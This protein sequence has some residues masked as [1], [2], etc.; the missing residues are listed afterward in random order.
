LFPGFGAEMPDPPARGIDGTRPGHQTVGGGAILEPHL[1]A[2]TL[3]SFALQHSDAWVKDLEESLRESAL[4]A[5]LAEIDPKC[6]EISDVSGILLQP[7]TADPMT[8]DFPLLV[9]YRLP[10]KAKRRT[11]PYE[12]KTTE[13]RAPLERPLWDEVDSTSGDALSQLALLVDL[14]QGDR[15]HLAIDDLRGTWLV[16]DEDRP[17]DP[18]APEGALSRG[19]W[20]VETRKVIDV[21]ARRGSRAL[22]GALPRGRGRLVDVDVLAVA[23]IANSL[24]PS[25]GG[26]PTDLEEIKTLQQEVRLS[27]D[28]EEK[29]TWQLISLRTNLCTLLASNK[30]LGHYIAQHSTGEQKMDKALREKAEIWGKKLSQPVAPVELKLPDALR[31]EEEVGIL[32]VNLEDSRARVKALAEHSRELNCVLHMYLAKSLD[33]AQV[34]ASSVRETQRVMREQR[35][36]SPVKKK[37]SMQELAAAARQPSCRDS[38]ADIVDREPLSSKAIV[39]L[40]PKAQTYYYL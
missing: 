8:E 9:S 39:D 20:L 17:Y 37:T 38:R 21:D 5:A 33:T 40:C 13:G 10:T 29:L 22:E 4:K 3:F 11:R 7:R 24:Y 32:R 26:R 25:D 30:K 31:T 12:K 19:T 6:V 18:M 1:Q 15:G 36:A 35:A 14:G 2:C 27:L 34:F 16:D 23:A 28:Q